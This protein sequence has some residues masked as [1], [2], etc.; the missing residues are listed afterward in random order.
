MNKDMKNITATF[1]LVGTLIFPTGA[2]AAEGT[3]VKEAHVSEDLK[4]ISNVY[5]Q[6]SVTGDVYGEEL[7]VDVDQTGTDKGNSTNPADENPVP[8][9]NLATGENLATDENL[10]AG[11]TPSAGWNQDEAGN[12]SYYNPYGYYETG[13]VKINSKWYFFDDNGVLKTN[14]WIQ[15]QGKYYFAT[16]DGSLATYSWQL[17]GG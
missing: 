8:D 10:A 5:D 4:V 12:W 11:E 1:L 17:W 7:G 2:L 15:D 14:Q 13:L 9:E 6:E 3:D 16:K